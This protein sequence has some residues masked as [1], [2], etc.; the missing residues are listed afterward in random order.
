MKIALLVV[1]AIGLG[2]TCTTWA[3]DLPSLGYSIG[4][5]VKD[6]AARG[7]GGSLLMDRTLRARDTLFR[8]SLR[9]AWR[10]QRVQWIA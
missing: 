7:I 3:N 5:P 9:G 1:S 6:F 4:I 2:A 10:S 8:P